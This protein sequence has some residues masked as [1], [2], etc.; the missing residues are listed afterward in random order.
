MPRDLLVFAP[1]LSA[2]HVVSR[3]AAKVMAGELHDRGYFVVDDTYGKE[4]YVALSA[5]VENE[6]Y[7]GWL[8]HTTPT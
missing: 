6:K 4:H 7:A 8:R 2:A 1:G 5:K 3:V